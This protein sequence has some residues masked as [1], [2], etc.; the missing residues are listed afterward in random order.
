[1]TVAF[2][3]ARAGRASFPSVLAFEA[4]PWV[5][6]RDMVEPTG[7]RRDLLTA[8]E[9]LYV[10]SAE[11]GGAYVSRPGFT[12]ADSS[13]QLGALGT[14]RVQLATEF[15]KINGTVFRVVVA[16][17]LV[18]TYN[19]G[20][21]QFT[22]QPLGPLTLS[23]TARIYAVTF[24]DRLIL[25]DGVAKPITWDGTAFAELTN[26]PVLYGQP[27]VHYAKL[28]GIKAAERSTL[29]WS[30][31]ADP[32]IGYEAGGFNNA[33]TLG[34]TDQDPL[35]AGVGFNEAML[36][37]RARS[38]TQITGAVNAEFQ[39]SGTREGVSET[40]GTL[41]P[42][43]LV[44]V[45]RTVFFV[46]ADGRPQRYVLNAGIEDEPAI[47]ELAQGA[48]ATVNKGALPSIVG[49]YHPTID[50]VLFAV[51]ALGLSD[52]S[53]LLAFDGSS[54]RY[55]GTWTGFPVTALGMWTDTGNQVRMVHGEIDGRPYVHGVPG[56]N[57]RDDN[58]NAG[59]VPITHFLET[60]T[61]GYDVI[62]DKQFDRV[63]VGVIASTNITDLRVRL[64]TPRSMSTEVPMTFSGGVA[65]WD[66][67]V[68]DVDVW[69]SQSLEQHGAVGAD[70][71]GRWARVR[72]THRV[73]G[74]SFGLIRVAVQAFG[75]GTAPG[76]P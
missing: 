67:A 29:V 60:G 36:V 52:P 56:G 1:M 4:G 38:M 58:F 27:W 3:R 46:D 49:R 35:T 45:G 59:A 13:Q 32:T 68:W 43:A 72:M 21:G 71:S 2:G 53:F 48:L 76:V 12:E 24:A 15:V 30:E 57:A 69:S 70:V 22:N 7:S 23:A 61:F 26:A 54:G 41:S 50:L 17:G 62:L 74:E 10:Q 14:R 16:G 9:N 55:T 51:P 37:F 39:S 42:D 18:Y 73:L 19:W 31:E 33:W 66:D 6:V 28:F 34:Q 8:A 47:W 44:V 25:T 75:L 40:V 5:G 11:L 65:L 63:D 64:V 20:T